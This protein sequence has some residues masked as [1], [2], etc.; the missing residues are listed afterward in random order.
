MQYIECQNCRLRLHS[1]LLY[2]AAENCPR[3]GAAL[4]EPR[5]TLG[6]RLLK[7]LDPRGR[8]GAEPPDWERITNA[9]YDDRHYVR[10]QVQDVSTGHKDGAARA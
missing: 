9:Q 7:A 10:R 8:T 4:H 6:E 1:G 2:D 3:C 5:P